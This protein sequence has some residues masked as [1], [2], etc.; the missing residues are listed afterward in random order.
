M[1]AGALTSICLN[2]FGGMVLVGLGFALKELGQRSQLSDEYCSLLQ[3]IESTRDAFKENFRNPMKAALTDEQE[4]LGSVVMQYA[5]MGVAAL[6]PETFHSPQEA[7]K[8]WRQ[9]QRARFPLHVSFKHEDRCGPKIVKSEKFTAD[10]KTLEL[11]A[12]LFEAAAN[13]SLN[14]Y[15]SERRHFEVHFRDLQAH[16]DASTWGIP[17]L[18]PS[19]LE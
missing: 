13:F 1:C 11:L 16:L 9:L 3:K 19:I 14:G 5:I 15:D 10:L 6:L 12:R 4:P 7:Q 8:L 17:P 2:V 18:R